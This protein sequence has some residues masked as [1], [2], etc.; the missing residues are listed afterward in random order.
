MM[1]QFANLWLIL[2]GGSLFGQINTIIEN[3]EFRPI[4]ETIAKA[5]PKS[6]VFFVNVILC[7]SFNA[8]GMELSMLVKYIVTMIMNKISPEASQTQRQLDDK[9]KPPSLVWG[10]KVPPVI[11]IFM[12]SIL[13]SKW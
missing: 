4:L 2:I 7:S 11:F 13:Y 5:V 9:K 3:P 12:V 8:F 10:Q 6:S 1:F